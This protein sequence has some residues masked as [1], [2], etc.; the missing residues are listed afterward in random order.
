MPDAPYNLAVENSG[1]SGAVAL[2]R[3]DTLLAEQPIPPKQRHNVDL[4]VAVDRVCREHDVSPQQIGEVYVSLGP[5]SFTGLRVALATAKMLALTLETK[6][7]GV[8]TL[9]LLRAQHPDAVVALNIKHDTAWSAGPELAPALRPLDE[10]RA[11][12]HPLIADKT[13]GA[14]PPVPSVAT[15]WH[16]GRERAKAGRFDDPLG[17]EPHYIR[18]PEA[19]TLWDARHGKA[20]EPATSKISSR[21]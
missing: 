12:K 13:D 16:I 6:V 4:M 15:L 17:L 11:L 20:D 3:A 1:R 5:G 9:D 7:V 14:T 8:P 18:Q 19:V 2:G 21:R 10:L